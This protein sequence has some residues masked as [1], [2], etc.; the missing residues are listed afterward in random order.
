MAYGNKM[1]DDPFP[2]AWE[3]M[4]GGNVKITFNT[5]IKVRSTEGI[6]VCVCMCFFCV[7]HHHHHHHH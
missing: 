1:A 4:E 3:I 6:E 7:Y 2:V 5:K